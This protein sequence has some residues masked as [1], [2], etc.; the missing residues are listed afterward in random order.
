MGLCGAA[1]TDVEFKQDCITWPHLGDNTSF[2]SIE[3]MRDELW[4][5][6]ESFAVKLSNVEGATLSE[7]HDEAI[8]TIKQNNCLYPRPL[9]VSPIVTAHCVVLGICSERPVYCFH[10][11]AVRREPGIY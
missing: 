4:E 8:G 9:S 10:G 11:P 1:K 3:T 2:I 6:D 5:A 7:S